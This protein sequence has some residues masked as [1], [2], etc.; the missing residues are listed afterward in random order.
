MRE[1]KVA[2]YYYPDGHELVITACPHRLIE[3]EWEY[4]IREPNG[5]YP[6]CP[7]GKRRLPHPHEEDGVVGIPE[8]VE[9]GL[10]YGYEMLDWNM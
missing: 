4:A 10:Y 3:D 1:F 6:F 5:E 7:V 8:Y 2:H 9:L